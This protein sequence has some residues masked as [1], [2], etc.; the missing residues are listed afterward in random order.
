MNGVASAK[1]WMMI[2][3]I[4]LILGGIFFLVLEVCSDSPISVGGVVAW[5]LGFGTAVFASANRAIKILES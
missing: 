2:G 1:L 4:G 3:Y 5:G